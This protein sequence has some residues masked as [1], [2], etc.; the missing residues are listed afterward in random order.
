MLSILW[1]DARGAPWVP[2]PLGKV[3]KM[4][5]MGE[6][7][8]RDLVY[9][10]GCGDGRTIATA[11]RRYGA[12]VVG[13]EIDPLRYLW[14]RVLVSALG[15]GDRVRLIRGDFFTQDLSEADAVTCYLLQRTNNILE[16]KLKQEL[17]PGARVVSHGFTFPGLHLVRQ[18]DRA[19]PYL[20]TPEPRD[21][22]REGTAGIEQL[23]RLASSRDKKPDKDNLGGNASTRAEGGKC[24]EKCPGQFDIP[25]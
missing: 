2:T 21:Q 5:A 15:L 18:D 19:K 12:R 10:L 23:T 6:T 22:C 1:T 11:A 14:C 9:D 13:I 4:L 7:G 24:L 20:Y 25:E 3:R 16:G 8:P 17:R